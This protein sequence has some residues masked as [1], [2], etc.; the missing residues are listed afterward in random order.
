MMQIRFF[1]GN[2]PAGGRSGSIALKSRTETFSEWEGPERE[3][4]RNKIFRETTTVYGFG[5]LK[6]SSNL[7]YT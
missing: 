5:G 2:A 4:E 1:S 3:K 6:M 7:E